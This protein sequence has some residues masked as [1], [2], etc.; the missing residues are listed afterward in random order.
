MWIE[1]GSRADQGRHW[2]SSKE[3]IGH[4]KRHERDI[5]A[6]KEPVAGGGE[7][8]RDK[9]NENAGN[10]SRK[11]VVQGGEGGEGGES[12]AMPDRGWCDG[13]KPDLSKM[14]YEMPGRFY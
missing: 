14:I 9:V 4:S 3:V 2:V 6:E 11:K 7:G 1:A 13:A 8:Q 5:G 12:S 10:A